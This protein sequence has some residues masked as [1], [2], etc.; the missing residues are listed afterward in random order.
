MLRMLKIEAQVTGKL[1][2]RSQ[3]IGMKYEKKIVQ[4]F[5]KNTLGAIET[6]PDR[7]NSI[8]L[9]NQHYREKNWSIRICGSI[10]LFCFA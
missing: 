7:L 4:E 8:S 10:Q 9:S 2:H 6:N 3:G 5:G 1:D